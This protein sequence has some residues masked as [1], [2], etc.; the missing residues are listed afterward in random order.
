MSAKPSHHKIDLKSLLSQ[1]LTQPAMGSI[2]I[3]KK[4]I[5]YITQLEAMGNNA[6]STVQESAGRILVGPPGSTGTH[7]AC[8]LTL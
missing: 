4:Y 5:Y 3:K 2:L 8:T 6:I 1:K 7:P